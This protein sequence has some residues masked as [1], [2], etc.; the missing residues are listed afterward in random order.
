[1]LRLLY[2]PL[3]LLF[4]ILGGLLAN[5]LFGALWK[6]MTGDADAPNSTDADRGWREVL[7]AATVQGAV[8]GL[9]KAAVDR[10]G[11]TGFRKAT[12]EW[13]GDKAS[14]TSD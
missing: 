7:T 6:R 2:R 4:G 10:G 5:A 14:K 12:G 3:G 1:M 9:V 13:P 11:A 8:F